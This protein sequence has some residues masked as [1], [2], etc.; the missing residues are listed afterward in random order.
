MSCCSHS[1]DAEVLFTRRVA[2]RELRDYRKNGPRLTTGLLLR[3]VGLP[4]NQATTLLDIGSGIGVIPH[5]LLASGFTSAVV[6]DASAAYLEVSQHEASRRGHNKRL[7]YYRGD[8]VDLGSALPSADV[9][10][11]DRVLCC[12]PDVEKLVESSVVKANH[13]YG[14]VYPRERWITQI[15]VALVNTFL[16]LRGGPF[17]VYVHPSSTVD[18]IVR[19]QGFRRSSYART[20]LWQIVTYVRP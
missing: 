6:V 16:R 9:V 5:E 2:Q 12:Y 20:F 18:S 7:T 8:F 19:R 13:V 1:V 14:L 3:A 15:G 11:L 17:R 4:R 10:T